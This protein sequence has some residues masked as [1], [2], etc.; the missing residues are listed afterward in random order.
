METITE[1]LVIE[2]RIDCGVTFAFTQGFKDQ[3][4]KDGK[5]FYCPNGHSMIYSNNDVQKMRD[6][7]RALKDAQSDRSFWMEQAEEKGR[8][9]SATRGQ[10]TKIKNRVAKGICP[11]CNRQFMNLRM[12]LHELAVI[13]VEIGEDSSAF[14]DKYREIESALQEATRWVQ[15]TEKLPEVGELA[16][17]TH[18]SW[19]RVK[20]GYMTGSGRLKTWGGEYASVKGMMW[21]PLPTPPEAGT[22]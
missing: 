6:L 15:V 18:K 10:V 16:R 12:L 8:S 1:T 20:E 2:T 9:L 22:K 21:Q 3:R 19:N 5:W 14:E 13:T 17:W 7:K 11:C 4:Q